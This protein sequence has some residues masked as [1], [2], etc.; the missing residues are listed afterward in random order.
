MKKLVL[1]TIAAMGL[2]ACGGAGS[3]FTG[4]WV[5]ATNDCYTLDVAA[6]GANY[7]VKIDVFSFGGPIEKVTTVGTIK[8]EVLEVEMGRKTIPF[9]F[10][11]STGTLLSQGREFKRDGGEAKTCKAKKV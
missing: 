9:T 8:N 3:N 11:K 1:V 6:N 2:A 7:I 4:Q 10:N 5:S